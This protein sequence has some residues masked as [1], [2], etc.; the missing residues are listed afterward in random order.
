MTKSAWP[1]RATPVTTRSPGSGRRRL[2]SPSPVRRT[3]PPR[4][5][6]GARKPLAGDYPDR[7]K[8]SARF[9]SSPDSSTVSA[10]RAG[11]QGYDVKPDGLRQRGEICRQ[12]VASGVAWLGTKIAFRR[13]A[14]SNWSLA[15]M[16]GRSLPSGLSTST[17]TP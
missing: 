11:A 14:T 15:V 2:E 12:S 17:M 6:R 5:A 16:Y 3:G 4:R 1:V 8:R 13:R 9:T 7:A 10:W